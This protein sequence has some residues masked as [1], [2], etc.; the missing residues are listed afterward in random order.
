MQSAECWNRL[1]SPFGCVALIKYGAGDC[2]QKWTRKL[3]ASRMA[4]PPSEWT[5]SS[6][7]TCFMSSVVF[8]SANFTRR[9]QNGA[10]RC[11]CPKKSWVLRWVM[12]GGDFYEGGEFYGGFISNSSPCGCQLGRITTYLHRGV[13]WP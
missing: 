3:W 12:Q 2:A 10:A 13:S 5:S 9:P 8:M 6:S 11:H 7:P 4:T 1:N